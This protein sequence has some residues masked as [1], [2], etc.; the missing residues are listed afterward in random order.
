MTD[1]ATAKALVS[2]AKVAGPP[3]A[4]SVARRLDPG[5]PARLLDV[6][7]ASLRAAGVFDL[8][9]ADLVD[10]ARDDRVREH[11]ARA[12]EPPYVVDRAGL[13]AAI[14]PLVGRTAD[15]TE[16]EV[17]QAIANEVA[18]CIAQA[19]VGDRLSRAL[20]YLTADLIS[21]REFERVAANQQE[22]FARVQRLSTLAVSEAVI[23]GDDGTGSPAR[24]DEGL[25]VEREAERDAL[26]RL[27]EFDEETFILVTGPA[28]HGKT[29][30]LWRLYERLGAMGDVP[31]FIKASV[32]RLGGADSGSLEQKV[33][34]Q[35]IEVI[36]SRGRRPVV[37]LD[38]L[39][40]RLQSE[41]ERD[42]VI[43]LI[44]ALTE[45]GTPV[46][47]SSRPE[48]AAQLDAL[49]PRRVEVGPYGAEL[50]DAVE[51]HVS[52]FYDAQE[53]AEASAEAERILAAE[54]R[55]L[56]IRE[57][58]RSPLGLRMIFETYAPRP[59]PTEIN[60]YALYREY[61]RR[62][63][64]SDERAGSA[65]SRSSVDC[66][67]TAEAVGLVMLAE[68][69]PELPLDRLEAGIVDF[70]AT[71]EAL[72]ELVRRGVL[73]RS[74]HETLRF[75]HQTFFEHSAGRA[76]ALAA[77]SRGLGHLADRSRARPDDSFLAPVYEQAMLCASA[78]HSPIRTVALE[79]LLTA[80]SDDS[81]S[82][83]A[84]A[85][86]V[87]CLLP[88]TAFDDTAV[89]RLAHAV[90][91]LLGR[92]GV[93][94]PEV[95]ARHAPNM[96]TGGLRRLFTHFDV[97]WNTGTWFEHQLLVRV[98]ERL[99]FRAPSGLRGFV[100]RHPVIAVVVSQREGGGPVATSLA[101]GIALAGLA[102]GTVEARDWSVRRLVQMW[103]GSGDEQV[104]SEIRAR[105]TDA[106]ADAPGLLNQS[107]LATHWLSSVPNRRS[108]GDL[109]WRACG[110][111]WALE[112]R[113]R[114]VDGVRAAREAASQ[115][116]EL[117]QKSALCGLVT[118]VRE[119]PQADP[120]VILA[121]QSISSQ[122]LWVSLV[123]APL[124][125]DDPA[126]SSVARLRNSIRQH[127]GRLPGASPR[128]PEGRRDAGVQLREALKA[129]RLPPHEL[130]ALLAHAPG[131]D[132]VEP[133]LDVEWMGRLLAPAAI[134]GSPGAVEALRVA[135]A[136]AQVLPQKLIAEIRRELRDL[137]P[138]HGEAAAAAIKLNLAV[139][140]ANGLNNALGWMV[141]A[142]PDV[143]RRNATQIR[144][145]SDSKLAQTDPESR[146]LGA[147]LLQ[148]LSTADPVH[149]PPPAW[150]RR[151]LTTW[152]DPTLVMPLLAI[153]KVV[154]SIKEE[155]APAML[156]AALSHATRK[157]V[158]VANAALDAAVALVLAHPE[159]DADVVELAVRRPMKPERIADVGFAA[160][161]LATTDAGAAIEMFLRLVRLTRSAE[162]GGKAQANAANRMRK[163][164][165]RINAAAGPELRPRLLRGA[166]N[167]GPAYGRA[168][169]DA[170]C[171]A[172]FIELLPVIDE[173]V[174][175]PDVDQ[176]ARGL[177]R[178]WK[179]TR[180]RVYG[181]AGWPE[182][183]E[184]FAVAAK[185]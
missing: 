7:M 70:G 64:V 36:R 133:W 177:I 53:A 185:N 115:V 12:V 85:L 117:R 52:R 101:R 163:A 134:G 142:W 96:I 32:L 58:V 82:R 93:D 9:A 65:R 111:L 62:R 19:K 20:P 13:A 1:P 5:E 54:A 127:V 81:S 16:A 120:V 8:S 123:L 28:G 86:Y 47:A 170:A 90:D 89:A 100:D 24:L 88:E 154:P 69:A 50:R 110:R 151:R 149:A 173:L 141:D 33:L 118:T 67:A 176:R 55:G 132:A 144:E 56:P 29:S 181:N 57:I 43:E 72:A 74:G 27:A 98:S 116:G 166:I 157:H 73:L 139:G 175:H 138:D 131:L 158:G 37:L 146:R 87:Y 42:A 140:D 148:A 152:Q 156:A 159:L 23:A 26:S 60:T 48:E 41:A 145:L 107:V 167:A 45:A 184:L 18:E 135:L 114:N 168:I 174:D 97:V 104:S 102:E 91:G 79:D 83:W 160:G 128:S 162:L 180:E 35:A 34:R 84:S 161:N 171:R 17:A 155:D 75:F 150:L 80:L 164:L 14:E 105:V 109:L 147:R 143:V 122:W 124:L 121:E 31:L 125:R 59:V 10:V 183:Y 95:L 78:G 130:S 51:R 71:S 40:V 137:S 30:L 25:Y 94:A 77:G 3:I 4:K 165:R 21:A 136:S 119:D 44:G 108:S 99:A 112:W 49:D 6:A 179:R 182:L 153:L 106:L 63:V 46:V 113:A 15:L 178:H 2:L 11:L 169:I 103:R 76:L 22:S 126:A 92:P 38:T 39:D 68:G 172:H 66:S 129:A 61:W